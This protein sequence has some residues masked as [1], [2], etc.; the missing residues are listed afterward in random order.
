[1]RR[2]AGLVVAALTAWVAG[3]TLG[4]LPGTTA[5]S[6]TPLLA[7]GKV[8]AGFS[9][10]LSGD[11]PIFILALGSDARVADGTPVDKGLGDSIHIIGI[12]PAKQVVTIIGFPRD[13]YVNIPGVGT[14]KINDALAAGGPELMA[15][16]LESITKIKLDYYVLTSFDGVKQAVDDVGGLTVDVPFS[17]HD[18]YSKSDFSPGV[19]TL[20]GFDVLA[21][22]RDR[23]SFS[24]GDFARSENQGRVLIAALTQFRKEFAKDPSALLDWI[25]AGERN[26]QT[27]LS[28][29]QLIDFG[30]AA[31][32][33]NPKKVTNLV[34][35]GS[36]ATAADGASIV[37]LLS[38]NRPMYADMAKDAIVSKKRQPPSPTAGEH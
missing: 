20:K 29:D 34:A 3:A 33:F 32:Q 14:Q 28:L 25:G 8:H 38:S 35:R 31:S 15:K 5:A 26:I 23:H 19:Q 11:K 22:A 24:E 6:A 17:M 16:T 30:F 21:F 10:E 13:S 36:I 4:S 1:V 18:P 9:P 37:N 27:D 7:V 12:N 2:R